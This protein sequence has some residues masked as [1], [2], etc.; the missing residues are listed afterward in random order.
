MATKVYSIGAS[1]WRSYKISTPDDDILIEGYFR[2]LFEN[3][4]RDIQGLCHAY[5]GKFHDVPIIGDRVKLKSKWTGII[6]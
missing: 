2:Q 6:R 1:M 5:W 3:T 4:P